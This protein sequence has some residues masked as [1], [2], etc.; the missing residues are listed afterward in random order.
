[1]TSEVNLTWNT[2]VV[3]G[4]INFKRRDFTLAATAD[5]FGCRSVVEEFC[6]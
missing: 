1:M 5:V 2:L 6:T 4:F 3:S